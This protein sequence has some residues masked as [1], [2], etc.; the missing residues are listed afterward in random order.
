MSNDLFLVKRSKAGNNEAFVQLMM[1]KEKLLYN[2]A[3]KFLKN[4]EDIDVFY[5]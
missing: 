3:R 1:K 4:E 5:Q 2:M